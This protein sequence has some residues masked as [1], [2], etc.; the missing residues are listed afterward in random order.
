[1]AAEAAAGAL[2]T[3]TAAAGALCFASWAVVDRLWLRAQRC[4]RF[5]GSRPPPPRS[6]GRLD[7]RPRRTRDA[8]TAFRDVWHVLAIRLSWRSGV[9]LISKSIRPRDSTR[10]RWSAVR[11]EVEPGHGGLPRPLAAAAEAVEIPPDP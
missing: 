2:L 4:R 6:A 8:C 9:R 1:M 10:L 3:A 7:C 11:L 5:A